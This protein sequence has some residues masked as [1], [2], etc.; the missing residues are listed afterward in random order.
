MSAVV[1]S[2]QL[3]L[4]QDTDPRQPTTPASSSSASLDELPVNMANLPAKPDSDDAAAVASIAAKGNTVSASGRSRVSVKNANESP[5]RNKLSVPMPL[6]EESKEPG[7]RHG[8]GWTDPGC[9]LTLFFC[10]QQISYFLTVPPVTL[11][12]DREPPPKILKEPRGLYA[13]QR[14]QNP[15]QCIPRWP[16]ECQVLPQR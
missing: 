16:S 1:S 12:G 5:D 4:F 13:V 2:C 9:Q 15:F 11:L 14:D 8:L 6:V 7:V 10:C 3:T